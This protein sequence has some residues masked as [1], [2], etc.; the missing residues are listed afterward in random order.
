MLKTTWVNSQK[1]SANRVLGYGPSRRTDRKRCTSP[2]LLSRT[3]S[4]VQSANQVRDARHRSVHTPTTSVTP[5]R[6]EHRLTKS[7]F[8]FC[9]HSLRTAFQKCTDI[10]FVRVSVIISCLL[11][12]FRALHVLE[13]AAVFVLVLGNESG[14]AVCNQSDNET[15][16]R[17]LQTNCSQI[18]FLDPAG[19]VR[20][21][22]PL[23]SRF[24]LSYPIRGVDRSH[25]VLA[26]ACVSQLERDGGL[27]EFR[28]TRCTDP[29]VGEGALS[30]YA[31]EHWQRHFR[32]QER[33]NS[34]LRTL[35]HR[36]LSAAVRRTSKCI[37]CGVPEREVRRQSV[38][39]MREYCITRD[40]QVL[41]ASYTQLIAEDEAVVRES[42]DRS[43]CTSS[44]GEATDLD[45]ALEELELSGSDSDG[46]GWSLIE[47]KA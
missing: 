38:E 22:H 47:G 44:E 17:R 14:G 11:R 19:F 21:A 10:E 25:T 35:V 33:R 24:L 23:I 27:P 39:Q 41:S 36:M 20:F 40:F 45:S 9:R 43:R 31:A 16:I 13:L 37:N 28:S 30:A 2:S 3:G 32:F 18:F 5:N 6:S 29:V 26:R 42:A 15:T 12:S 8:E 1:E 7:E 34:D 4:P 46:D